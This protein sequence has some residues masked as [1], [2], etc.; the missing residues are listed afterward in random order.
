MY[1][2]S[3]IIGWAKTRGILASGTPVGQAKKLLEEAGEVIAEIAKTDVLTRAHI[4][5]CGPVCVEK[6]I[7]DV[8]ISAIILAEMYGLTTDSCISAAWETIKN[9]KGKMVN[10]QFVKEA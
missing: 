6:E 5:N 10:G 1:Q 2:E 4:L 9:R 7:G 8:L 3:E